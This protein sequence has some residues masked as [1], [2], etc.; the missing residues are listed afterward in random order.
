MD[1]MSCSNSINLVV[2]VLYNKSKELMF[3]VGE[4]I[5]YNKCVDFV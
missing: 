2:I 4:F 1:Y 3:D 5:W